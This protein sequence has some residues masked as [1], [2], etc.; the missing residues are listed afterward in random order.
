[1]SLSKLVA[2]ALVGLLVAPSLAEAK[3][4]KSDD[5]EETSDDSSDEDT[6]KPAKKSKK[7]AKKSDDDS[8]E[9]SEKPA[10][11]SKASKAAKKS[12]DDDD[13]ASDDS[14][15]DQGSSDE[16]DDTPKKKKKSDDEDES[17]APDDGT[18]KPV[19]QDL[20]GHDMGS[21]KKKNEFEQD[22]FYVDKIDSE[23]TEK[24]TL[25]QGSLQSTTFLYKET[26][27][28]YPNAGDQGFNNARFARLYTDLRLQTD[29]RHISASDWDARID[30][31]VRVLK[32]ADNS[33]PADSMLTGNSGADPNH[34]QSGFNGKNEYDIRELWLYRSGKRTDFFFGRQFIP[35]FGGLKFDGLR[36]DY[37]KSK[38]FT[39]IGFGGTYPLRGSRSIT[40]DYPTLRSD[41]GMS[42]GRWVGSGGF[43]AAYRTLNA[44]GAFGGVIL[45]P[46]DGSQGRGYATSTGYYRYGST[47]DLYH[48]ALIDGY[49]TQGSG[50][51][52]LSAGLNY[53]P[54]Q[55]LRV[56]AA[57][58]RVDVD[59]LGVQ[60]NSFLNTPQGSTAIEN[61]TYFRRLAT[62]TAR[63]GVSA[64]LGELNRFELSIDASYRERGTI[65]IPYIL[66]D[67][68][69]TKATQTLQASKGAELH[70][71]FVDR[72][73]FKDM[74]LG[75]DAV[76]TLKL[77][78]VSD[79]AFQRSEILAVRVFGARELENGHGEWEAEVAYT[80]SVDT[81][82]G[83]TCIPDGSKPVSNCYGSSKGSI[84]SAGGT[85]YYRINTDWMVVGS[86]YLTHQSLESIGNAV[87][88]PVTYTSDPAIIGITGFGRIAYRF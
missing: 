19:K 29:F 77:G 9:D 40:S 32:P 6:E 58:N 85:I 54:G 46:I 73:S 4:K 78:A 51:T 66:N 65:D 70:G 64:A 75:I 20:S 81:S 82:T 71:S 62:N 5:D 48:F 13:S 31:R 17:S 87:V 25:I 38:T 3:K 10:K 24:G 72:R 7:A 2:L 60:A 88:P 68:M 53:K 80:Q 84:L 27:G 55:R 56:T 79:P 47:I 33:L 86:L 63:G 8:D 35:D 61:E 1:V 21:T 28:K 36:F 16:D 18:A 34:P 74:R 45:Q 30:A 42:A 12:D 69:G 59:T 49:G 37:A 39:L 50:L 23:K 57:F 14:D 15:S 44:Y 83:T 52:N 41:D 76:R 11:K 67:G 22:R 26:G 43:G